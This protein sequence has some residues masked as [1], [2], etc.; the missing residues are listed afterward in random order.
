MHLIQTNSGLFVFI[1]DSQRFFSL[2]D[3]DGSNR[4]EMVGFS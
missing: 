2:T 1:R 4:E 3:E